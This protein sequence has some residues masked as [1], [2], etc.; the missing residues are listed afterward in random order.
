VVPKKIIG[1][2]LILGFFDRG[3]INR[4]ALPPAAQ[5]NLFPLNGTHSFI[6]TT[7]ICIMTIGTEHRRKIQR[8]GLIV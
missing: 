7:R 6:N 2:T 8:L 1:L 4:L 5:A 3:A